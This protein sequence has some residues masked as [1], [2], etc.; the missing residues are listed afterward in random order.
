MLLFSICQKGDWRP[1][2]NM[3]EIRKAEKAIGAALK[4][5]AKEKESKPFL[6]V[7]YERLRSCKDGLRGAKAS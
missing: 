2:E 6:S 4:A 3:S 1:H 7:I 5:I